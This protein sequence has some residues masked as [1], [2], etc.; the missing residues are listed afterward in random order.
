ML[1]ERTTI[2]LTEDQ[3]FPSEVIAVTDANDHRQ[4][5][6][7]VANRVCNH[8]RDQEV[9]PIVSP[10]PAKVGRPKGTTHDK[11]VALM[12]KIETAK[13]ENCVVYKQ[14]MAFAEAKGTYIGP[15]VFKEVYETV[16]AKYNL[17]YLALNKPAMYK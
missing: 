1:E 5:Q 4:E 12:E 16:K 15:T 6:V 13:G 2:N 11:H 8:N 7:S 17:P 14:H 10:S 3:S 9:L